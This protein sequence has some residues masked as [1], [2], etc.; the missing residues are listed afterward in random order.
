MSGLADILVS[1][2]VKMPE[3]IPT[4]EISLEIVFFQEPHMLILCISI[5][6]FLE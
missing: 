5:F 2:T 6:T 1:V 4:R 3:S